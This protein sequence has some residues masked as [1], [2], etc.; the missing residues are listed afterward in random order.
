M[1]WL[2]IFNR[3][4]PNLNSDEF[5]KSGDTTDFIND[6]L[7][8]PSKR[9]SLC[10]SRKLLPSKKLSK[11]PSRS[12]LKVKK[13]DDRQ[14]LK[15]ELSDI[16]VSSKKNEP[17]GKTKAKNS[18][19]DSISDEKSRTFKFS[20][21]NTD[22][23]VHDGEDGNE[24]CMEEELDDHSNENDS[25]NKDSESGKT[26]LSGMLQRIQAIEA[27]FYERLI[28][29]RKENEI[30]VTK[31]V[32]R[33]N[34]E[35]VTVQKAAECKQRELRQA[36]DKL[37]NQL[38]DAV[39]NADQIKRNSEEKM[40]QLQSI[41]NK[42][43]ESL[44]KQSNEQREF[45]IQEHEKTLKS[46]QTKNESTLKELETN[47]S[48]VKE[49]ELKLQSQYNQFEGLREQFTNVMTEKNEVNDALK[50]EIEKEKE[51]SKKVQQLQYQTLESKYN[52]CLEDHNQE[53]KR[54]RLDY[55]KRINEIELEQVTN[56]Q[57]YKNKMEKMKDEFNTKLDENRLSCEH[58][59]VT[60]IKE[61]ETR[62]YEKCFLTKNAEITLLQQM[63]KENKEVNLNDEIKYQEII[64]QLKCEITRLNKNIKEMRNTYEFKE[65]H[66]LNTIKK[67]QEQHK[68]VHN[69]IDNPLNPTDQT[70]LKFTTEINPFVE[71]IS[72]K[73][74]SQITQWRHQQIEEAIT[75][76]R[77]EEIDRLEN[78][79][80][81]KETTLHTVK[82]E[83][84]L[85]EAR[86]LALKEV[87][88]RREQLSEISLAREVERKELINK[89]EMTI[90]EERCK[91]KATIQRLTQ[92][93]AEQL[94]RIS[95]QHLVIIKFILLEYYESY[96]IAHI[97]AVI[98][99]VDR[100]NESQTKINDLDMIL[101]K[102]LKERKNTQEALSQSFQSQIEQMKYKQQQEVFILKEAI[103][104]ERTRAHLAEVSLRQQEKAWNNMKTRWYEEC[105]TQFG[106]S[107]PIEARTRMEA[108]I[109]A[110]R[111]QVNLLKKRIAIMEEDRETTIIHSQMSQPTD[112]NEL[113]FNEDSVKNE[114]PVKDKSVVKLSN[115]E[116]VRDNKNSILLDDNL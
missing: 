97:T 23:E 87:E 57:H 22:K 41:M 82:L 31:I 99:C 112:R 2:D 17:L 44:L 34:T 92:Q 16:T 79:F 45:L 70:Q 100:L 81:E 64:G 66:L 3:T 12:A 109:E 48:L 90:N 29:L 20:N 13:S 7:K 62:G 47:K 50:V 49:L 72:E 42:Q 6:R 28:E 102:A 74:L 101:Q 26:Y 88:L 46:L 5:T 33:K 71:I 78:I 80:K 39:N 98:I 52:V 11:R 116:N 111:L 54:I 59:F 10:K 85:K 107:L 91:N 36:I 60:E 24:D 93:H 32:N 4:N 8:L 76:G 69:T 30:E 68:S 55:A 84:E 18:F 115:A 14:N 61:A 35:L 86:R 65:S 75:L 19:S 106:N 95:S 43:F 77:Q 40:N 37:E 108:T 63:I 15:E 9:S 83:A 114:S 27:E 51:A 25:D 105:I 38:S 104:K 89:H 21:H 73:L 103:S 53:L 113:L 110:L 56:E 1:D 94:K 67:L 58:R 96:I